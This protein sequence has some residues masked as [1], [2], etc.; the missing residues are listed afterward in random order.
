M[1]TSADSS[2]SVASI[3]VGGTI[4]FKAGFGI[5]QTAT[6]STKIESGNTPNW[7]TYTVTDSSYLLMSSVSIAAT[8]ALSIVF[9][10]EIIQFKFFLNNL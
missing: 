5:Y 3:S 7:I 1:R 9:W 2:S 6:S 10:L 8:V 4:K